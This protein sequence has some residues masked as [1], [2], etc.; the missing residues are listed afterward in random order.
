[1]RGTTTVLTVQCFFDLHGTRLEHMTRIPVP[2]EGEYTSLTF[3]CDGSHAV[4]TCIATT[5]P[6]VSSL[7]L[8]MAP[9]TAWVLPEFC[10]RRSRPS[11]HGSAMVT[12][13]LLVALPPSRK[14][15][16]L[17][18]PGGRDA[19]MASPR[20]LLQMDVSLTPHRVL[21]MSGISSTAWGTT[22][23]PLRV[24]FGR[25]KYVLPSFNDQEIVALV[26]A[27]AV[28]RCHSDRSGFEGPWTFSPTTFT[29][30]FYKLLFDE[31]WGTLF[32]IRCQLF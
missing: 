17:K 3:P 13:G 22:A 20:M 8:S 5:L 7:R 16:D 12:C 15:L 14:W 24:P 9:T 29:N 4:V 28:G 30:D 25:A 10:W 26:G 11:S 21:R 18:F 19:L 31:K 6:C 1:M 27:H 2:A 23:S 32:S